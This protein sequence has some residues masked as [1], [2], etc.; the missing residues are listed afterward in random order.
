MATVDEITILVK[1]E[2]DSAVKKLEGLEKETTQVDKSTKKMATTFASLRDVMQ[3]PI[4]AFNAVVGAMKGLGSAMDGAIMNASNFERAQSNLNSVLKS[5]KGISGMTIESLNELAESMSMDTLFDDADLRQ[6]QAVLLTFKSIGKD[7]FPATTKAAADLA[8]LL[9]GDLQSSAIMLGKALQDPIAGVGALRKVGVVLSDAQ[10][11][12]IKSFMAVND[13]ASAQAVILKEVNSELGG[14]ASAA[15]KTATGVYINMKKSLDQVNEAFGL[16][17]ANAGK[18]IFQG[19]TNSAYNAIDAINKSSGEIIGWVDILQ[20][21]GKIFT[22]M[23]ADI[24]V[25][26]ELA[27]ISKNIRY[28]VGGIIDAF[29]S[30]PT[31][32]GKGLSDLIKNIDIALSFIV[33]TIKGY[34]NIYS[35]IF[36]IFK[37]IFSLDFKKVLNGLELILLQFAKTT[38]NFFADISEKVINFIKFL[39]TNFN[40][41]SPIKINFDEND[42]QLSTY[43]KAVEDLTN[44]IVDLKKEMGLIGK[45][46]GGSKPDLFAGTPTGL[47]QSAP[48]LTGGGGNIGIGVVSKDTSNELANVIKTKEKIL[49]AIEKFE[50]QKYDIE[51]KY[52]LKKQSEEEKARL[53]KIED[54][55]Q[56]YETIKGIAIS[57]ASS[58]ND[59]NQYSNNQYIAGLE[60][61]KEAMVKNGEDTIAIEEKIKAEKNRLGEQEFNARKLTSIAMIAVNTAEAATKAMTISPLLMAAVI[62]AGAIQ[63][64]LVAAQTYTPMA[65]GGVVTSPTHALIGEAGPE[66]VI[67]LKKMGSMGTTVVINQNISGSVWNTKQLESLALGAYSK[68]MRSY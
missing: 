47:T 44:K 37:G 11:Q 16:I 43:R 62:A 5:T 6:A 42:T 56:T 57:L 22:N 63:A 23:F 20:D 30:L 50:K 27:N 13:I 46:T 60:A 67:P 48:D 33:G 39:T 29:A 68:A 18:D 35:G 4:A 65:E 2:V 10:E 38:L 40:K 24:K 41:I 59:F 34:V 64:G 45:D 12:Q 3:G 21:Y 32:V 7:I 51:E 17:L 31:F 66:A 52:R 49:A 61:Q 26:D 53:K 58:V 55:K 15:A 54:E 9:G 36:E 14:T 8:S 19:I 1:A 25:G 28:I